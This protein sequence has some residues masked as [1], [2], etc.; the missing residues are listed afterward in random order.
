MASRGGSATARPRPRRNF[1]RVS[2]ME[3]SFALKGFAL[4]HRQQ[5]IAQAVALGHGL[6]AGA[7]QHLFVDE[8]GRAAER[9]SRQVPGGAA[10][11]LV[12][13]LAEQVALEPGHALDPAAVG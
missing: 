13:A 11:E 9:V 6:G 7:R 5:K 4:D 12:A 8:A 3:P 10:A 1:L 2:V